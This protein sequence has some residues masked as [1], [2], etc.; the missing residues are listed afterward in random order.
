MENTVGS[1]NKCP[2]D[3]LRPQSGFRLELPVRTAQVRLHNRRA[4][5]KTVEDK[6]KKLQFL[7]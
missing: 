3:G 6:R 1:E 2:S 7:I 4:V 5:E